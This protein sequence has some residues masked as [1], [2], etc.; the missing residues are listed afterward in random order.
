LKKTFLDFIY[1]NPNDS[2]PSSP[3]QE[4]EEAKCNGVVKEKQLGEP[5]NLRGRGQDIPNV[6]VESK[7]RQL[8]S[9]KHK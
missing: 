6:V 5:Q 3:V 7:H 8:H 4:V 9:K 2:K 1:H